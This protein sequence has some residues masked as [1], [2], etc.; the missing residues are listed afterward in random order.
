MLLINEDCQYT[1]IPI[2]WDGL[3]KGFITAMSNVKYIKCEG[4][5]K[6]AATEQKAKLLK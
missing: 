2:K 6:L 3:R 4:A 5:A 1:T